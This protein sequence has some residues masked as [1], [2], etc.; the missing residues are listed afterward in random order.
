MLGREKFSASSVLFIEEKPEYTLDLLKISSRIFLSK[1][2]FLTGE[3]CDLEWILGV[4]MRDF[5][6]NVELCLDRVSLESFLD[7]SIRSL[8]LSLKKRDFLL[9]RD[10]FRKSLGRAILLSVSGLKII[11][12]FPY[13]LEL[14]CP[15]TVLLPP[16]EEVDRMEGE[17]I[18]RSDSYLFGL[19]M[20][21]SEIYLR[22]TLLPMLANILELTFLSLL[23]APRR[24][25]ESREGD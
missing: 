9:F 6:L 8:P 20:N 5:V 11:S 10:S 7:S 14:P 18:F 2:I 4:F 21:Y 3:N 12:W 24:V 17:P 22:T 19:V 13:L 15:E 23:K 25:R 1:F 16:S